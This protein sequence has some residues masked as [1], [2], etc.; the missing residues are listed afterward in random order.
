MTI[1]LSEKMFGMIALY[2]A[3]SRI[4]GD[5]LVMCTRVVEYDRHGKI[6]SDKT[7]DGA[8][9]ENGAHFAYLF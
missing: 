5:D 1:T 3:P 2:P 7:I 9:I 6:E 8:R 4:E